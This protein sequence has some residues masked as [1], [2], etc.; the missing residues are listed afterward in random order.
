M[1]STCVVINRNQKEEKEPRKKNVTTNE[2][3]CIEVNAYSQ[4]ITTVN[5]EVATEFYGIAY[6]ILHINFLIYIIAYFCFLLRWRHKCIPR[7]HSE[8]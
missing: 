1:F 2:K 7:R 4:R 5:I 3:N 8:G 6:N